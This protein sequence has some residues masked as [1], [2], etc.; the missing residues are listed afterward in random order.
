M[1]GSAMGVEIQFGHK[2]PGE[3]R[4]EAATWGLLLVWLGVMVVVD[5]KPGV[6]RTGVG[7]ILL[8]SAIAQRLRRYGAG[9]LLWGFGL[10]FLLDGLSDL[11]DLDLSDAVV[12]GVLI[13]LGAAFLAR[14]LAGER[15]PG[16]RHGRASTMLPPE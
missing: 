15:G 14:A 5:E 1:I 3:R 9:I 11:V 12:A 7:A 10:Y 13:G 4:L 6:A 2:P 8:L 16:A